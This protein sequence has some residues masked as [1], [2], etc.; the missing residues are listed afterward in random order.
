MFIK[1]ESILE[2]KFKQETAAEIFAR[3]E[4]LKKSHAAPELLAKVLKQANDQMDFEMKAKMKNLDAK[5][6]GEDWWET[7]KTFYKIEERN[8]EWAI[9][10]DAKDWKEQKEWVYPTKYE[11]EE[12]L[13]KLIGYKIHDRKAG[14]GS[15]DK[16]FERAD[17]LAKRRGVK[18]DFEVGDV[19]KVHQSVKGADGGL[20][21]KF[22]IEKI[23]PTMI[24]AY[25][26]K[27]KET[28]K[29]NAK[30]LR[31]VGA[32][33]HLMIKEGE[34]FGQKV[35][36]KIMGA[37]P[38]EP[39]YKVGQTVSYEMSPAQKDGSGTGK[40]TKY[41]KES[42]FYI[43]NGRPINHFEIKKVV[44]ES[45]IQEAKDDRYYMYGNGEATRKAALDM[46]K[47]RFGEITKKNDEHGR[48]A[49]FNKDGVQVGLSEIDGEGDR[50]YNIFRSDTVKTV[51]ESYFIERT[52]SEG[53]KDR[54]A[55]GFDTYEQ[56]Q[57]ELDNCLK[58]KLHTVHKQ[59]FAI[60]ETGKV[61]KEW[62]LSYGDA[63]WKKNIDPE[64]LEK[65]LIAYL[66]KKGGKMWFKGDEYSYL[67]DASKPT[68]LVA[69]DGSVIKVKKLIDV[70]KYVDK[71]DFA[72][73]AEADPEDWDNFFR[74]VKK[75]VN[76]DQADHENKNRMGESFAGIREAMKMIPRG[77][78]EEGITDSIKAGVKSVKRGM[79]GWGTGDAPTP[80]ELVGRNKEYD[81]ETI[82]SLSTDSRK[83]T[84]HSPADIQKRVVDREMKKR[85]LNAPVKEAEEVKFTAYDVSHEPDGVMVLVMG[86]G[87]GGAGEY[88]GIN[89]VFHK[90]GTQPELV[91]DDD[92][93][94]E[95]VKKYKSK[96]IAAATK[97][98]GSEEL[99]HLASLK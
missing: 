32:S 52:D 86:P 31:G 51:K 7:V 13:F 2:G 92:F 36:N 39:K 73:F 48:W 9:I 97:K 74:A 46:M 84:K 90:P 37:A 75:G 4:S 69:T 29:F 64:E 78:L 41:N 24:V 99:K 6:A 30:T 17:M 65:E 62:S 47:E 81:D 23:T 53:K 94:D 38:K 63:D 71:H 95:E 80:K 33:D 56:A 57:K 98:L 93:A 21:G 76:N 44:K 77:K 49:F 27:T 1:L 58:H 10:S 91:T 89:V 45:S 88:Y 28:M 16:D 22:N 5:Y 26:H 15:E 79:Q 66:K 11:A 87:D 59:K 18:E 54:F 82:K 12:Q 42:G 60:K 68:T 61:V 25:D 55:G 85:G 72:D 40:I 35:A 70:E 20:Y 83:V 8:N 19:V 67:M 34:T 3:Y 43:I 96:I 14:H 50:T